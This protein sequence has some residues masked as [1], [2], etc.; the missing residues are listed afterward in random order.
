MAV[1]KPARE[2]RATPGGADAAAASAPRQ[3]GFWT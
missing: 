3:S 1:V 2:A